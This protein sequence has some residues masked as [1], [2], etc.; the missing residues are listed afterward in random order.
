MEALADNGNGNYGYIDSILEAKKILVEEMNSTLY[1]VAKDVKF[2]VEFNPAVVKGYR[3]IGYENRLLDE[4]DFND[5]TKDAGEIGSGHEIMAMYEVVLVDSKIEIPESD[6]KYQEE[7]TTVES[8]EWLT[9]NVRYKEPDEDE[10]KLLSFPVNEEQYTEAPTE[11][12]LF[13]ATVA[14]F[15]MLLRDSEYKG[16]ATYESVMEALGEMD[17]VKDDVYK[18]EFYSLVKKYSRTVEEQ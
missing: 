1:T 9:I 15:G 4:E 14:E 5:D 13:A 7:T 3:L 8:S 17:C 16:N 11:N 12:T 6:L 18:D 2:Q 10:S